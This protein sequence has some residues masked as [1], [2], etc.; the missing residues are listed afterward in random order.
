[1]P[2]LTEAEYKATM[3]TPMTVVQP[4]ADFRPVP[5]AGYVD[6]IAASDPRGHD[7]TGRHVERVYRDPTGRFLHVL[8]A[9][10]TPNV[11]LVIVVDEPAQSIH[12]HYVLDLN[13]E[14]GLSP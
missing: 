13:K 7:F 10:T 3:G 6:A 11:F 4:D 14:Y 1:M 9:A 5:L 12:G 8:L 2:A